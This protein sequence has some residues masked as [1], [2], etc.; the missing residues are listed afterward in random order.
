MNKTIPE[1]LAKILPSLTGL[2]CWYVSCGGAAGSTFQLSLGR[3]ITRAV[4][5]RNTAHSEEFRRFEG[6]I[7]LYVWCAW[8]LD[9]SDG[10][11]TS[12]DDTNES[13]DRG[14][15]E[16]I[17]SC[18]VS[19]EIFPPVWDLNIRFS[20][21]LSLRV[22]C[23]HVPGSPSFDGNWDLRTERLSIAI[24]PGTQYRTELRPYANIE[25]VA[26]Q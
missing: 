26:P 10:P 14:L 19:L 8:R 13:V 21:S 7:G 5:L 18:I 23:D 20:N 15:N 4:P 6:E 17:G 3:K 22:F 16:L 12:W 24:G 1:E 2:E 25:A 11:L 9:G